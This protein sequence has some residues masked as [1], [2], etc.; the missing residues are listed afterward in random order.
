[1]PLAARQLTEWSFRMADTAKTPEVKTP[2]QQRKEAIEAYYLAK[3]REA[4]AALVAKYPFL[5]TIFSE[6]NHS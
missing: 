3:T 1:M 2:E 4:K 6:A 5:S